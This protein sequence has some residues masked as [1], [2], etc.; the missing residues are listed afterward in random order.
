MIK[1]WWASQTIE[2]RLNSPKPLIIFS[3]GN[4]FP[5]ATY[6]RM[7]DA[8]ASR[9]FDV[10][11]VPKFGHDPKFP[12]T[13]N[14]PHLVDELHEWCHREGQRRQRKPWLVGHSLG[15]FLS[16][17]C[18]VRHPGIALGVVMLDSPIVT[19]WR[20]NALHVAKR[21]QLVGSVSPGATS[22][23]RRNRWPSR[24]AALAHFETKKAFAK[25]HPQVLADYIDHATHDDA[26]GHRVLSF[27]R[28]VETAIYNT[29]P[30]TMGSLVSRQ[31][32]PT[33]V[34]FVGG[35]QSS[36][37]KQVGMQATVALTKGRVAMLEGTHLFPMERPLAT[38][39][40]VDAAI[41]SLLPEGPN[42]GKP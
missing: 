23:K 40:A 10:V 28:E 15:G 1:R 16:L 38:A 12:V 37:I 26:E 30:H 41:A 39:A 35:T 9:G 18:A 4:S 36:E 6:R 17:M 21:T 25:W 19:G 32:N 29:L 31:A 14:W 34:A 3:H 11:V 7:T 27:D 42:A 22:R 33:P 20:A 13:N 24:D 5:G 2:Q 8:L